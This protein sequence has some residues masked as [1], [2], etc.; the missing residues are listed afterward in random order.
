VSAYTVAGAISAA[1]VG[2]ALGALGRPLAGLAAGRLLFVVAA[3]A[4]LLALREWG[5]VSFPLP[6][7]KRQTEKFWVEDFGFLWAA[8]MWGFHIGLGFAT[9]ITY[10]GFWA[11]VAV[12][13]ALGDPAFGVLLMVTYWLGRALPTWVMPALLPPDTDASDLPLVAMQG[14]PAFHRQEGLALLWTTVVA[15]LMALAGEPSLPRW[16]LNQ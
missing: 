8:A 12:V 9:R 10:G 5:V 15:T 7:R 14:R 11:L 13:L 2:A 6:E 4:L 3:L 1:M 16:V